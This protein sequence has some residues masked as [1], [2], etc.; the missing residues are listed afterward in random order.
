MIARF[1]AN[2]IKVTTIMSRPKPLSLPFLPFL[3]RRMSIQSGFFP[4]NYENL[5]S[6]SVLMMED[7][8][9][10]DILGVWRPEEALLKKELSQVTKVPLAS[11][12][13]YFSDFPWSRILEGKKILVIHPF[14][15]SIE[16]QYY[17][18]RELLFPNTQTL[19]LF[20]SLQTLKAVQ[21][22][23]GNATGF[24]DWFAALDFMKNEISNRDFDIAIIGCGAYGF[25][26]AAHVKRIGKQAIH[27]GGA[28]QMLFGI[29]GKR[30]VDDNRFKNI[31]N[32]HFIYPLESEKP[33]NAE[34]VEEGCYW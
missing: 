20:S 22:I 31:I 4:S 12:E 32:N 19:P 33:K 17:N 13:P 25:P 1:G 27:L 9:A 6:F 34:S 30:W 11:L 21:S 10:L 23:A 3:K 29:K 16:Y 2:E 28:T 5:K 18:F 8:K 14:T 15:E 7:V 24:K 26:L